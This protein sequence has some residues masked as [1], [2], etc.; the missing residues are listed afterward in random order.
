MKY[1]ILFIVSILF[2]FALLSPGLSLANSVSDPTE[3]GES[4]II[5]SYTNL[6]C[7]SCCV[8][9]T[10]CTEEGCTTNPCCYTAPCC[11][12]CDQYSCSGSWDEYRAE[13]DECGTKILKRQAQSVRSGPASP[14]CSCG[15]CHVEWS[16]E[17]EIE[18]CHPWQKAKRS[19]E[20]TKWGKIAPECKCDGSCL[21]TPKNPRYYD[22]PNYPVDPENPE[23]SVDSSDI[24]LPVKLDWD[25]VLSWQEEDGV[26]SYKIQIQDTAQGVFEQTLNESEYNPQKDNGSCFLKSD[27]THNWKVIPCCNNGSCKKWNNVDNWPFKTNLAPELI[28]PADPDWNGD[29]IIENVPA[30][31]P[32]ITLDWCDVEDAESYRFRIYLT[33]DA[34]EVCHP[35]LDKTINAVL[36]S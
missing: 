23:S 36:K 15:G 19:C 32:A 6:Y 26:S 5:G 21:E 1:K 35:W 28:S 4:I 29:L 18:Q 10:T 22:N 2:T 34:Q 27:T 13:T 25:D 14:C 3:C 31:T 11:P 9:C 30:I 8:P 17:E 7:S 20:V 24:L 16:L 33:K 12:C